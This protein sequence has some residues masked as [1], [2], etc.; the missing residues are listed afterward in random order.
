[1]NGLFAHSSIPLFIDALNFYTQ[2]HDRLL[3]WYSYEL[4]ENLTPPLVYTVNCND[5]FY[6]TKKGLLLL[7]FV[8]LNPREYRYS[9]IALGLIDIPSF[10]FN[11]NNN[12]K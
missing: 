7:L 6:A 8:N 12:K 3:P 11:N 10:V 5:L 2:Q 1:M 9:I 4:Q